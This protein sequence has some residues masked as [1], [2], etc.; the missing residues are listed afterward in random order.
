MLESIQLFFVRLI[1]R[2]PPGSPKIALRSETGLLSMKLRIWK[3][4]CML[5]H[6]LKGLETNT[7]ANM[8]YREQRKN[9]WPGLAEEVSQIC[10]DLDIEDANI[11]LMSKMSFRNTVEKACRKKDEEDMKEGMVGMTKMEGLTNQDCRLK[12]YMK[13]KSLHVV[14]DTFRA[15]T[16]LVEGIKG[17][18]KNLHKGKDMRC[19]G[20]MLEVDTQSH[21]LQCMEY[22]DLRG[23]MDLEKDEDMVKYFREV[24]K[25][26]MKE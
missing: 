18:Y 13:G 7:L 1:L 25:R 8:V 15:R 11:T 10:A 6:H 16:Q 2:V 26:R 23:D 17:N 19:Q 9:K 3:A 20:C 4:K 12:E 5:V 24:L 14:R 22:E 21:V